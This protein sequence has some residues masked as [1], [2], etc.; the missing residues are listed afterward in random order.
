MSHTGDLFSSVFFFFHSAF[1]LLSC[2]ARGSSVTY[3]SPHCRT[4]SI[5]H[6]HK[7]TNKYRKHTHHESPSTASVEMASQSIGA[8]AA[9][10]ASAQCATTKIAMVSVAAVGVGVIDGRICESFSEADHRVQTY[11]R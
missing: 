3:A 5:R 6:T 1:R 4:H 8:G 10:D 2:L 7:Y 9:A 11:K